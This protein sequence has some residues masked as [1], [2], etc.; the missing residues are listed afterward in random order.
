MG[1]T[2]VSLLRPVAITMLF[3]ALAAMGIVAYTRL[4]VQRFPTVSF[5]A[6]T[7]STGYPGAPP[8]DVEA[9]VTKRIEDGVV[10]INGTDAISAASNPGQSRVQMRFVEGTDVNLASIDV[11]RKVNTVRRRLPTTVS[12]PSISKAGSTAFPVMDS[13]ICSCKLF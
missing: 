9:L 12:D 10:G 1:L 4:P 2:R 13:G 11:Q 3:L 7:V 6:V 5:P 8:E